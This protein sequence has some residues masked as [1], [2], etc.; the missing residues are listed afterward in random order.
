MVEKEKKPINIFGEEN[1]HLTNDY[2]YGFKLRTQR[3]E[4]IESKIDKKG[5]LK[6][7]RFCTQ[8]KNPKNNMW[9]KSKCSIYSDILVGITE[10]DNDIG[11]EIVSYDSLRINDKE[12]V[13][14]QFENKY[15]NILL[16][17]QKEKMKELIAWDRAMKKVS[18]KVVSGVEAENEQRQSFQEQSNILNNL[19]EIERKKMEKK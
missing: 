10:F 13:I 2:P 7:Q 18:W 12:D 1:A 11:K 4:W 8:T 17:E 6:G 19:A 3:K 14:K 15:N 9:N 5:N 16:P